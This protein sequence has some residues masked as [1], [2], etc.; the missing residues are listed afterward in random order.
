MC[1]LIA[2]RHEAI[3]W[4]KFY[5]L[6]TEQYVIHIWVISQQMLLISVIQVFENYT[7]WITVTSPRRQVDSLESGQTSALIANKIYK[8]FYCV[9]MF[10][11][12]ICSW[13]TGSSFTKM[14]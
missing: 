14:A 3:T 9:E 5:F 4:T 8:A 12:G 13:F 10:A 2:Q 1:W 7:F 6:S 11:V